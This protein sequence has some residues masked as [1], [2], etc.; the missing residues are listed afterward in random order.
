MDDRLLGQFE[1]HRKTFPIPASKCEL[2]P[3]ASTCL[4]SRAG[5]PKYFYQLPG[6][7]PLPQPTQ[8][9]R[10]PSM[11]QSLERHFDVFE[12]FFYCIHEPFG[13]RSF[14]FR[15]QGPRTKD[16]GLVD[17]AITLSQLQ[18][19]DVKYVVW[20][21]PPAGRQ[22]RTHTPVYAPVS[23]SVSRTPSWECTCVGVS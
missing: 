9:N 21:P 11:G 20:P 10:A 17:A 14:R 6:S 16:L 5:D 19:Q 23:G 15:Y 3:G 12:S 22:A 1:R 4:A 8:P 13:C 18:K 7:L 2:M